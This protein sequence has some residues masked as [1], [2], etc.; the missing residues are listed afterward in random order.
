MLVILSYR[1]Y[2]LSF[3]VLLHQFAQLSRSLDLEE[4]LVVLLALYLQMD[5][6]LRV[7]ISHYYQIRFR[8]KSPT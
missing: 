4:H 8:Y 5:R 6:V 7:F 2:A 3:A 1:V